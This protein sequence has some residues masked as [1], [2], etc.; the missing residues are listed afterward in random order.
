MGA[1]LGIIEEEMSGKLNVG[2]FVE[3]ERGMVLE[4]NTRAAEGLEEKADAKQ[5]SESE[6]LTP[7]HQ[8]LVF[9]R[10]DYSANYT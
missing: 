10:S 1:S 5:K 7:T 4:S 9:P 8:F 3:A 2:T 6:Q